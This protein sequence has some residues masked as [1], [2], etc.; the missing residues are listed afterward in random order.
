MSEVRLVVQDENGAKWGDFHGSTV[1]RVV[2]ALSAEPE[3]IEELAVALQRFEN[4]GTRLLSRGLNH[5][6]R[7]DPWDAGIVMIDLPGLL[8]VNQSSY[9]EFQHSSSVSYHNGSSATRLQINY[10]LPLDWSIHPS[11][12]QWPTHLE[13]RSLRRTALD[14]KP[15]EFIYGDAMLDFFVERCFRSE[16]LRKHVELKDPGNTYEICKQF[17]IEWL[18]TNQPALGDTSP[19]SYMLASLETIDADIWSRQEQW[20]LT[21]ECPLP[22][23]VNSF[24]HKHAN[25]GSQE[26]FIY[27]YMIEFILECCVVRLPSFLKRP[28][29]S[30][31]FVAERKKIR[32][33]VDDWMLQPLDDF[34]GRTPRQLIDLERRRIPM[35]LTRQ[36][37]IIDCDC[38]LCNLMADMPGPSFWSLDG[39]GLPFE[40]AF[41]TFTSESE[42]ESFGFDGSF[43]SFPMSADVQIRLGSGIPGGGSALTAT[44]V[45][46]NSALM[47]LVS[48]GFSLSDLLS[49]IED[50][51]PSR[52]LIQT[53]NRHFDN[54][55]AVV[56]EYGDNLSLVKPSID[57][58][59]ECLQDVKDAHPNLSVDCEEVSFMLAALLEF[60]H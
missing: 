50:V 29:P 32:K 60:A 41:S 36:E 9:D 38:P 25:L 42:W 3:T 45:A 5:G 27:Q 15:R 40:Y 6:F 16:A 47:S 43:E 11:I 54:V 28:A 10:H 7:D 12:E 53:L 44:K 13:S 48:V 17:H 46:P 56:L 59:E 58:F 24:A 30:W 19:R 51:D 22:L 57:Q 26:Y 39:S 52:H 18:M 2:A 14:R 34:R 21:G 4:N 37:T 8:L 49:K 23:A 31:D 1:S 35:T 55:R 33:Q 20:S